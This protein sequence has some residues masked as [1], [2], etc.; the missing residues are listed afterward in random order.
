MRYAAKVDQNQGIIVE[1]LRTAGATVLDLHRVGQGCPDLLVGW[2]DDELG[3]SRN[4]LMEVK[5]EG[6]YP[7][8]KELDFL[9]HWK[10]ERCVVHSPEEALEVIGAI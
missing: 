10:G 3:I 8:K 5:R 9:F 4:C 2:Y 1:A 6:E 7:N